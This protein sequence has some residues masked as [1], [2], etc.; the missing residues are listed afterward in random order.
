AVHCRAWLR[1]SVLRAG[2]LIEQ[3]DRLRRLS[4]ARERVA[5]KHRYVGIVRA[6]RARAFEDDDRTRRI[7]FARIDEE[8]R[9]LEQKLEPSRVVGLGVRVVEQQTG[10][11]AVRAKRGVGFSQARFDLGVVRRSAQRLLQ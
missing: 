4:R 8:A 1:A 3:R 7:A 5:Q 9:G 6:K 2:E 11:S 10:E